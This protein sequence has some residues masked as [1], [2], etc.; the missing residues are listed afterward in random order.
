MFKPPDPQE[1]IRSAGKMAS[2]DEG[3]DLHT[4]WQALDSGAEAMATPT[5]DSPSTAMTRAAEVRPASPGRFA[6]VEPLGR[7]TGQ[8]SPNR[9]QQGQPEPGR[10]HRQDQP[11]RETADRV[12][13]AGAAG[14]G[15]VARTSRRLRTRSTNRPAAWPGSVPTQSRTAERRNSR[16][17]SEVA[18]CAAVNSTLNDQR[19]RPDN[20]E[21]HITITGCQTEQG[22]PVAGSWAAVHK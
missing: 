6:D 18:W 19:Q 17:T 10:D 13:F 9:A 22:A 8:H 2:R 16:S 3:E 11:S 12:D 1:D 4:G 20:F 5:A 14:T 21:Q 7:R 15:S